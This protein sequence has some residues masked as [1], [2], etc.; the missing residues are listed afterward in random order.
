MGFRPLSRQDAEPQVFDLSP[1]ARFEGGTGIASLPGSPTFRRK[2]THAV[3]VLA[4]SPSLVALLLAGEAIAKVKTG[5][6]T[7]DGL[8]SRSV[9]GVGFAPAVVIIKGNDTDPT[10]DLTS[11]V[12]RSGNMPAG[13][14]KPLKG[15]QALLTTGILVARCRRFHRR[16]KPAGQRSRNPVP[17]RGLRSQRQS[18]SRHLHGKREPVNP[19]RAWASTRTT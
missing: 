5:T 2:D 3:L 16:R 12:L 17:L 19:S 18:G 4:R 7:G 14:S 1:P 11:A 10:D 9:T 8:A 6:Y 13:M 15:D